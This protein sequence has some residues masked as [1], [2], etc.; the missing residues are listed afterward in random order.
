M[1]VT[2]K[3]AAHMKKYGKSFKVLGF[4]I[5]L[6]PVVKSAL[7]LFKWSSNCKCFGINDFFELFFGKQSML[8]DMSNN[9][10]VSFY[11]GAA[12][13]CYSNWE[14]FSINVHVHNCFI[15]CI[16][17]FIDLYTYDSVIDEYLGHMPKMRDHP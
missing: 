5:F 3:E 12:Y 10:S 2:C 6:K 8:K 11:T 14:F 1:H 7:N 16:W 15:K 17:G 13:I 4:P 9:R